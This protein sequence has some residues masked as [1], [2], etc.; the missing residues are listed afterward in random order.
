[1][2]QQWIRPSHSACVKKKAKDKKQQL[3]H[4]SKETSHSAVSAA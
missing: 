3:Q 1:M 2:T 4:Q